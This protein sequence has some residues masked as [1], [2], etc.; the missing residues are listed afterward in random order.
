MIGSIGTLVG[1]DVGSSLTRA[2]LVEAQSGREG[3]EPLHV[4]G[5]GVVPSRGM[6][7]TAITHLKAATGA[8]R[9]S[10]QQAELMAG[11]EA[12]S[13]Y[14]GVPG[15]HA[16][17]ARS[18]GVVAVSGAEITAGH[19]KRVQEVGR[20]VPVPPDRELIHALCQ[21]YSVDGRDGILDPVGMVATRLEADV[22]IITAESS[23][24]RDLAKAV[25]RAG[26]R[27]E[28]LVLAPLASALATLDDAERAAGVALIEVGGASTDFIVY[29]NGRLIHLGSLRWGGASVTRDI[30]R[31]LGVPE[32]EASRLKERFGSAKRDTV[33]PQDQLEVSGPS[34]GAARRVSRELLAHIIEQRLDEILGLVYEEL[35]ERELLGRLGAGIV[36]TGGSAAIA[37]TE[38]LARSVFNLPVRIGEPG[39]EM[40]GAAHAV[41]D[42]GL[43][44]GVGLAMYGSL[45][46]RNAGLAGATRAIVRVG[47]WL[48]E[49]F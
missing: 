36:L 23:V 43:T 27:P 46:R 21:E 39:P 4:L 31:G 22:S 15:F 11:R 37:E 29:E 1:L 14:V 18:R 38:A 8:V 25:D 35:A 17:T 16:Q 9:E 24:C 26:Y 44:T 28:E 3:P 5:V 40:T 19:V 10:I 7:A 12:E 42:P 33:D 47:Q 30:A 13:V 2:V 41:S 34:A 6:T 45:R 20:A 32:E 48:R 49:F